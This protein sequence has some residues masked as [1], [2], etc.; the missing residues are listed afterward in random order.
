M[1]A[2]AILGVI[3]DDFTGASD[4]AGTLAAGGMAVRLFV[5][6]G[7]VTIPGDAGV[8]ALKSRNL[9]VADAVAQSLGA[10]QALQAAGANRI[11]FK[12]CST[13]DSTPAG[14]IGQVAEALAAALGARG[15]V[16]CP[17]FPATGRTVYQ[18]HLF[19][20]DRLISKTGMATHP[21]TPMTDPD[22]VRWLGHQT[23]TPPGHVTLTV[24][25]EG[26]AAVRAALATNGTTLVVVDAVDE[27]DLRTIGAAVADAP[28]VTGA[29]GIALG[30]AAA[31][32]GRAAVS[33]FVPQRGPALLLAGSCSTATQVQVAAYAARHPVFRVEVDALL[34]GA[35][36]QAEA[37]AFARTHVASAPLIASTAEPSART[38][39]D[40]GRAAAAV[41]ALFAALAVDAVAGGVDRLV[42]AGGETSGAVVGALGIAALDLGPEIDPGVPALS[43]TL[44]SGA[45]LALAL[46]SG[47]F[48][49]I[50]FLERAVRVLAE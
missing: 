42:V 46:K 24:V 4:V 13:F 39:D 17:A 5:G 45:R 31:L 2:R 49:A 33:A 25:R 22:I 48:G 38:P 30:L 14:N 3:A 23:R 18:G 12:Y 28:L 35:P 41:E 27:D 26:A 15:V 7:A 11:L 44:P 6:A 19:V 29:S 47:N 34:D 36:V 20:G 8:I 10:L 32:G 40:D 9:P 37:M 16:V 50:D 1:T 21:L 43:T